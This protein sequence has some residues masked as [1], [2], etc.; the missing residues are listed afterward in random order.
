MAV[1]I[2]YEWKQRKESGLS[3]EV[4]LTKMRYFLDLG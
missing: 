3:D 1:I 2:T 4:S